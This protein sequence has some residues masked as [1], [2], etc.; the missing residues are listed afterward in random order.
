[1]A[2][3]TVKATKKNPY[4]TTST[5]RQSSYLDRLKEGGG[6]SVRIDFQGP[7]LKKLDELVAS[8]EQSSRAE[9]VRDLVRK[10]K[11]KKMKK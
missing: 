5:E 4:D 9:V 8:E 1:M 10:A 11:V 2:K 6:A 3:A 7:D